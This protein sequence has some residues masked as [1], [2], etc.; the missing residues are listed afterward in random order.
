MPPWLIFLVKI[1]SMVKRCFVVDT[2]VLVSAMLFP[3]SKT[4]EAV[5]KAVLEGIVV[6]SPP[7]VQE[8]SATLSR[9]KFDTYLSLEARLSFLENILLQAIITE[10]T[11]E[12]KACRDATDDMFLELAITTQAA[13]II[14]GDPDLLALHP[15]R[16]IPIINAATFLSSF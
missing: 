3:L 2:N 6:V 8:L 13:C 7:I 11:V 5:D 9:A 10:P 4:K 1:T 16:G 12:I 15:F 14:T